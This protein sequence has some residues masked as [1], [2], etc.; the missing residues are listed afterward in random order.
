MARTF[1]FIGLTSPA[2]RI[3]DVLSEFIGTSCAHKHGHDVDPEEC[4][5]VILIGLE[6]AAVEIAEL[7]EKGE[8][9]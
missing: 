3:R 2:E 4:P 6:L 1:E 5:N 7:I 9:A 8:L